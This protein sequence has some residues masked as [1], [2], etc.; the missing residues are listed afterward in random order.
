[1]LMIISGGSFINTIDLCAE[2]FLF[3]FCIVV[4]KFKLKH[5][6]VW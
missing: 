3:V 2:T 1:V 5:I 6:I 4:V